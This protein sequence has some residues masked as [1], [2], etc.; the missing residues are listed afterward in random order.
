MNRDRV[1]LGFGGAPIGNLFAA[2]DD[3]ACVLAG[4]RS[5]AEF[6]ENLALAD[7]PIPRT[8]WSELRARA[9]VAPEAPLPGL[10]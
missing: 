9:L 3:G 1:P 5:T 7:Y 4:V 2:V 8:F 6:D 10:P